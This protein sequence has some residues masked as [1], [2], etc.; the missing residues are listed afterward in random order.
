MELTKWSK[1]SECFCWT[2]IKCMNV[3][4]CVV[5]VEWLTWFVQNEFFSFL[6]S[7]SRLTILSFK[8]WIW[9][10][11]IL[12]CFFV[13]KSYKQKFEINS[14]QGYFNDSQTSWVS[15]SVRIR[16]W[17]KHCIKQKHHL[18]S[19]IWVSENFWANTAIHESI[20]ILSDRESIFE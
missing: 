10:L 9:S 5:I 19:F 6:F 4:V 20:M 13:S 17:V 12:K 8:P 14:N 15:V 11:A 18:E 7:S 1:L 2:S 3:C 16:Q